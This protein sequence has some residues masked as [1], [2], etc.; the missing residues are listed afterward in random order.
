[1][2]RVAKSISANLFSSHTLPP[3]Q[4]VAAVHQ[5]LQKGQSDFGSGQRRASGVPRPGNK[6]GKHWL[7]R[8][9]RVEKWLDGANRRWWLRS[10]LVSQRCR[11]LVQLQGRE[12]FIK[13]S[14]QNEFS[15]LMAKHAD[16]SVESRSRIHLA[17]ACLVLST[18]KALLPF[19][20]DE[21]VVMEIIQEH[22]GVHAHKILM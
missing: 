10:L 19:V 16:S 20:R 14:V 6:N 18:H 15:A 4:T 1:M 7:D 5:L 8:F 2:R 21:R 22:M 12:T 11:E 13:N 17:V 3:T 9:S